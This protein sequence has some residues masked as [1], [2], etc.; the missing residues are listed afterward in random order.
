MLFNESASR[1]YHYMYVIHLQGNS[2]NS[3]IAARL[4]KKHDIITSLPQLRGFKGDIPVGQLQ[5]LLNVLDMGKMNSSYSM[6]MVYVYLC[7]SHNIHVTNSLGV[8]R[9]QRH[10]ANTRMDCIHKRVYLH[11]SKTGNIFQG[12]NYLLER[13]TFSKSVQAKYSLDHN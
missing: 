5:E 8:V 9:C 3:Y 13:E 1:A 7:I 10:T 4:C 6:Y 11:G 12:Q 2:N